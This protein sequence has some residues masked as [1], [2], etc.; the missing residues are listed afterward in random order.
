MRPVTVGLRPLLQPTVLPLFT[1]LPGGSAS[2]Q[3]VDLALAAVSARGPA[4]Q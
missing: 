2:D 3:I 1:L 4:G